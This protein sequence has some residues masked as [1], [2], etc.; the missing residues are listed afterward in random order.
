M[1][2]FAKVINISLLIILA[3]RSHAQQINTGINLTINV[4][5]TSV[6][7]VTNGTPNSTFI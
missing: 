2:L 1:H 5:Q 7:L 3:Q 4:P 6:A